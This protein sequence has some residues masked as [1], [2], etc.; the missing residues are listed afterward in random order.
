LH[1]SEI[2]KFLT[3]RY[4]DFFIIHKPV[5]NWINHDIISEV[6]QQSR[7]VWENNIFFVLQKKRFWHTK[8]IDP[9]KMKS[10]LKRSMDEP[11]RNRK[12]VF[13]HIPK[14]AG[15]SLYQGLKKYYRRQIYLKIFSRDVN[16]QQNNFIAGHVSVYE[17][18]QLLSETNCLWLTVLRDP[19]K[20][21]ASF[22]AH[23]RRTDNSPTVTPM[24]M[25]SANSIDTIVDSDEWFSAT[26]KSISMLSGLPPAGL[27]MNTI[28]DYFKGTLAF[29][30]RKNVLFG[31]QEDMP[32]YYE[33]IKAA[34]GLSLD[35]TLRKNTSANYNRITEQEIAFL[36]SFRP[37]YLLKEIELYHMAKKLFYERYKTIIHA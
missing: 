23:A 14:C 6:I 21:I 34:T 7:L 13:V 33:M 28:D 35:A 32:R 37:P 5:F 16:L 11:L 2:I 30:R 17:Y 4:C 29:I 25:F 8:G 27:S 9:A 3:G 19:V 36:D 10:R 26:T 12:I 20:R 24:A 22:T 18:E 15:R 31:I 1:L